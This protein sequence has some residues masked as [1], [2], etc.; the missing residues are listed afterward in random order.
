[1]KIYVGNLSFNVTEVQIRELFAQYGAV[2]DAYLVKER[3]TDKPRGFAFVM[4]PNDLQA[5]A[6]IMA[7]KG[8]ELDG[9]PL[10]VTEAKTKASEAAPRPGRR[11]SNRPGYAGRSGRVGNRRMP[12]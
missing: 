9:Q 1:M 7:L 4:M 5:K 3:G 10:T 8:H 6:A 2:Q 11:R 12:R